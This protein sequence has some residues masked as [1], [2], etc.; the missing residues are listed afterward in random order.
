M[1]KKTSATTAKKKPATKRAKQRSP[2]IQ[3][4]PKKVLKGPVKAKLP[5]LFIANSVFQWG[6]QIDEQKARE[7]LLAANPSLIVKYQRKNKA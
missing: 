4:A 1:N 3:S 7:A 5:P 2:A 6:Q